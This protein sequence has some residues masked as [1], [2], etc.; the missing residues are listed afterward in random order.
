MTEH[1]GK[2]TTD[3]VQQML[4]DQEFEPEFTGRYRE[5]V[6]I[7]EALGGFWADKM[8]TDILYRVKPGKEATVYCLRAHPST[9]LTLI[10][11]KIYRPR[12]FRAMRNDWIYRQ[13]RVTLDEQGKTIRD[14]RS[15]LAMRKKTR[16]GRHLITASWNLDEYQTL[17]TLH[18]AGAD[19]PKPVAHGH[20][21]ILM[22]HIGDEQQAAPILQTI[23]LDLSE[24]RRVFDRLIEKVTLFLKCDL[25]H[26][27]LSAYNVLYWDGGATII[28]F[29][30]A[31]NPWKNP[32]ALTLRARDIER[33]CGYFSR[34]G[35]PTDPVGITTDLW[36]RLMR[37][38]L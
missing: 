33:L 31:V 13:G 5:Y 21:C 37:G 12:A 26:A 4:T 29:P 11:A 27:D 22:E 35:L 14:R 34:L 30:Q 19:V 15:T 3:R 7:K 1:A 17:C 6:W 9:N 2:S 20:T 24:A 23:H 36:E 10:A 16:F 38:R 18:A 25:I 8:F 28:D 32:S